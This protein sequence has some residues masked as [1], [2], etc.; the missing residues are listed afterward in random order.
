MIKMLG[1]VKEKVE[2]M[3]NRWAHEESGHGQEK[4]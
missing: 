2:N 4:N 3:Q 1:T